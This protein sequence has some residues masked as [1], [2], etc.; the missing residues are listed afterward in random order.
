[1][2]DKNAVVMNKDE[3]SEYARSEHGVELD[4]T[5][6]V[7]D[8]RSEVAALDMDKFSK[9]QPVAQA[10]QEVS[11]SSPFL[12]HPVNGRV[13]ATTPELAKRGDMIP[14]DKDGNNT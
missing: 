10:T 12:R 9:T 13:Y 11:V 14:C 8:L 5:K 4:M 6:K 7:N 2:N 3:L 1:M